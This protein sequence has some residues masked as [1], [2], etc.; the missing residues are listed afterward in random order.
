MGE[1]DF[2]STKYLKVDACSSLLTTMQTLSKR[3]KYISVS[4]SLRLCLLFTIAIVSNRHLQHL[5]F[6]NEICWFI[7]AFYYPQGLW[8]E[9]TFFLPTLIAMRISMGCWGSSYFI[10]NRG[11]LWLHAYTFHYS[12][13]MLYIY[14]NMN[15]SRI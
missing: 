9:K 4:L 5:D 10:N 1:N 2:R 12:L 6:F 13:I 8:Y 3:V 15:V 7:F 14:F 11:R